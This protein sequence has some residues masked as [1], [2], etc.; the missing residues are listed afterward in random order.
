MEQLSA[1]AMESPAKREIGAGCYRPTNRIVRSRRIPVRYLNPVFTVATAALV[2]ACLPT[3]I[4]EAQDK[5]SVCDEFHAQLESQFELRRRKFVP[6]SDDRPA[7]MRK[8]LRVWLKNA[9]NCQQHVPMM[10]LMTSLC[11]EAYDNSRALKY[12]KLAVAAD[13]SSAD[14]NAALGFVL[15]LRG[16]YRKGLSCLQKAVEL[17][18]ADYKYRMRLCADYEMAGRYRKAVEACTA[19]ISLTATPEGKASAWYVRGRAYEALIASGL[20]PR[21]LLR[22]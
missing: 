8:L 22:F 5:N 2:F 17:D 4:I 10:L 12:A 21:S 11:V 19:A 18:P 13:A 7:Q 3:D 15:G 14:A 16:S 9:S 6:Y 1:K 20:I